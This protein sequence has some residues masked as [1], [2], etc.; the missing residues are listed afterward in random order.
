MVVGT[1]G[2]AEG[3]QVRNVAGQLTRGG[4]MSAPIWHLTTPGKARRLVDARLQLHYAAQFG[5]GL[6]ISYLKHEPDDSHTNLGRDAS[7]DALMSRAVSTAKGD[8]AVGVRARDLTLLVTQGGRVTSTVPLHGATIDAAADQLRAALGVAGLDPARYTLKRHYELPAHAVAKGAAFDAT[9]RF[10]FEEL[11]RWFANAAIALG[12]VAREV[13][14][15]SDVRV[16]PHHFDIATLVTHANGASN[17]AGLEPGDAY[18]AEPYFYV[19]TSPQPRVE[20]LTAKIGGGGRWHTRDWIG[21]VLPGSR[22]T[23]DVLAQQ[24]Q[25]RDFIDSALAASRRLVPQI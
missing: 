11:S 16:W 4:S 5:T 13:S 1:T 10:A 8:V 20:Q 3:A 23:G 17:G 18:F 22:V 9:D 25:V 14:G 24:A 15:A 21:A 12:R 6:G 7:L 2:V 19:N